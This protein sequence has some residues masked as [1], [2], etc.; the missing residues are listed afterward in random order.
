MINKGLYSILK[1]CRLATLFYPKHIQLVLISLFIVLF[2][3]TTNTDISLEVDF[4]ELPSKVE[5]YKINGQQSDKIGELHF[6]GTKY[7]GK[8]PNIDF[9]FYALISQ[10]SHKKESLIFISDK[11]SKNIDLMQNGDSLFAYGSAET[12]RLYQILNLTRGCEI[13]Y[14]D[15]QKRLIMYSGEI[16]KILEIQ[17]EGEKITHRCVSDI[18]NKIRQDKSSLASL[19][20]IDFLDPITNKPLIDSVFHLTKNKYGQIYLHDELTVRLGL[21]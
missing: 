14:K 3:C 12:E 10:Y 8:I 5:V 15:V 19:Y 17:K 13:A 7:E 4:K 6:D 11:N 2:G 20:A 21:K 18:I 9:G 16:P 1:G